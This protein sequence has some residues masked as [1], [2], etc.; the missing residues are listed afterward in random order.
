MEFR[1]FALFR[2][3]EVHGIFTNQ[4]K[5]DLDENLGASSDGLNVDIPA[6]VELDLVTG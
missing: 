6:L 3:L 4:T 5:P 1:G 2:R